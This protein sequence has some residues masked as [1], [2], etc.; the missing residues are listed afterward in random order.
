MLEQE[1][2]AVVLNEGDIIP[3]LKKLT[4][5]DKKTLVPFLKKFRATIFAHKEIKE[6]TKWGT[7][8]S[9][10]PSHSDKQRDLIAK[11]CFV[12]FSKTDFKRIMLTNDCV[13]D[14]YI[15][16]ILP[17]YVPKWY[18]AVINEDSPWRLTYQTLMTLYANGWLQPSPS[19]L[20]A[21]LPYAIIE[22]TQDFNHK[23]FYKPEALHVY[24]ETLEEH[25][26]LLFEEESN[27][28]NNYDYLHLENYKN[29]NHI[30]IDTIVNLCNSQKLDRERVLTTTI[31]TAT[32]GFN[33]NLSGWFYDL[34]LQLN[35]TKDEILSLQNELA[36]ALGCPHSK[37]INT[38][39]KFYKLVAN[40]KQFNYSVFIE[41]ASI[42]LNSE[43]KSVVNS[44]LM[45]L[46]KIAKTH[47]ETGVTVSIKATEALLNLDENIQVR[48]AKLIANYANP[49][50]QE[51]VNEVS[52]YTDNLLHAAKEL[53]QAYLTL[54][55]VVE[56]TPFEVEDIKLLTEA[57]QIPELE[58]VDDLLF[59]ISQVIDN[60]EVYHTDL[61]LS[62]LPKLNL[63]LH[64]ENVTK[65][66]PVFN[67]AFDLSM[68]LEG[69][70]QIGHLEIEAASYINDFAEILIHKFPG[71]LADYRKSKAQ[72]IK[73][74]KENSYFADYYKTRLLPI[75]QRPIA[76]YI[77]QTYRSLCI[78]SKTL[79]KK[80]LAL[81]LLST[82]THAPC[83][84]APKTLLNRILAYEAT[85]HTISLYDFQIAIGRL[86]LHEFDTE[87][88]KL[89]E[90]IQDVAI[91]EVLQYH[92][93]Q[94]SIEQVKITRPELWIQSVLSK[95]NEDDLTYFQELLA[96]P[97]QK[98]TG[99]YKWEC[100]PTAYP[101]KEYDYSLG[102]LVQTKTIYKKMLVLTDFEAGEKDQ[103]SI[104]TSI[105]GIFSKKKRKVNVSSFYNYSY[106]K[107]QE[108]T[109]TIQPHDDIK[110]L[111]LSP[112][113]P[114][115]FLSQVIHNNLKESTFYDESSKKNMIN[116]LKGLHELWY[117]KDFN[118]TTY[119][120]LATAL[121]CSDKVARE[122]AA[123]VW[124]KTTAENNLNNIIL[125]TLLGK[126]QWGEYAPM[127]RFTDLL[128]ASLFNVS[129]H[130]NKGLFE[131]LNHMVATMND[132]PPR[133]IKKLLDILL[134]LHY[135]F[136][137][138]PISDP[139]K[140]KLLVWKT[141]K[142][143][144]TII[145]KLVAV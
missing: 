90:K 61:L 69:N 107:K 50:N 84:I 49:A 54:P 103:E 9:Y 128:T 97:L 105:K 115:M 101:Y 111:L 137:E 17:W 25:I 44:T 136:P 14:D 59:F 76:D 100:K 4:P 93:N 29:G 55:E 119:L 46:D 68:N 135:M 126:L 2:E 124:I 118:E 139:S 94:L 98:E 110:F 113:N 23:S 138:L 102:K 36:T 77:Y 18:S 104:I 51:V 16:H 75:E 132:T 121:L 71:A 112:N 26:W 74:L 48:A 28:N 8:V 62:Y 10:E 142:T 45:I 88:I 91:R 81:T 33:K 117:R 133:G 140:E 38:V 30:W 56:E 12:C 32:K 13:S 24:K 22:Q 21:R 114:G 20:I 72:K 57:N 82:P 127:K 63:L 43:T 39:L 31:Y 67:R 35:P 129:A 65:L 66:E 11:A 87:L 6:K 130:H 78:D 34:L 79:L 134:E 41:N 96:N 116:L 70:S 120:F 15:T 3:V 80:G 7:S 143:L 145:T 37:V 27:I 58:T 122:L 52:M 60:N 131:V 108:Y 40:H 19:L 85:N 92:F 42:L 83:W 106:F 125:G 64:K 109:T 47:K 141:S 73:K 5:K 53:L 95:N 99:N 123:E 1:I 144:D 89:I 86:P